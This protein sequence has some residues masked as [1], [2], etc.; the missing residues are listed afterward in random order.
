MRLA[1]ALKVTV[2]T[3]LLLA[4]GAVAAVVGLLMFGGAPME[5]GSTLADGKVTLVV[6][7]MGPVRIAVYIITLADGGVALVDAG[8][9][10][11]GKAILSALK[12]RGLGAAD[13]RAVFVTHAHGDHAG[14]ARAFPN[15][16]VLA[17]EAD[18]VMLRRG[19]IATRG[20]VD[21]ERGRLAGTAFEAFALPGHTA[22]SAAFLIEGVLF[23]GDAA[24]STSES[25][26]APNDFAY[27]ADTGQNHRSLRALAERLG[28]RRDEIHYIAFGHQGPV[29][30]LGPLLDWASKGARDGQD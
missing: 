5:N 17:L 20:L 7:R 8:N 10:P 3:V 21:G 28:P 25:A 13:V 11:E 26:L 27:T 24:A 1:R 14:A 18:A 19:G 30:G 4:F 23:L 29:K 22:G 6:D 12:Q 2:L 15:A 9:D 16:E